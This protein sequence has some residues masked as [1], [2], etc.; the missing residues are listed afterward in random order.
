[1][2]DYGARNYDPAIGRWMNI[3]PLAETSRRWSPYA[4]VYNNPMRFV[5]PDGMQ[6]D[7][8]VLGKGLSVAQQ[9]QVL[10]SL[11]ALTNDKLKLDSTTGKVTID[12]KGTEN[13]SKTLSSGTSLISDL[14]SDNNTV[15]INVVN[16]GSTESDVSPTDAI[17]GV[18]SDAI[19]NVDYSQQ[20]NVLTKDPS[21]GTIS[22]TAT[23]SEIILGHELVHAERSMKGNA[24]DYSK[25]EN[26]SY[27][28]AN[29]KNAT[30]NVPPAGARILSRSK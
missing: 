26:F 14:I 5:D 30:Q 10:G 17:N 16:T 15:T 9:K 29:G 4:Y 23:P 25:K 11:Q 6:A 21:T 22:S 2:Y 27:T 3:D 8:I 12:T 20:G 19:V 18:G 1:M 7:D 13:S 28:D 24:V